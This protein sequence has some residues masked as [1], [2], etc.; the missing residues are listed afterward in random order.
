MRRAEYS[1][2]KKDVKVG[3][4]SEEAHKKVLKIAETNP[5]MRFKGIEN[6]STKN[7]RK[8][9]GKHDKRP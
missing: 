2:E 7:I 6:I 3:E 5:L 4:V 1:L 8:K 9:Y